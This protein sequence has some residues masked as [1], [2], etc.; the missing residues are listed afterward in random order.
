[1]EFIYGED[2][3]DPALMEAKSG[4]VVDFDH[5]LEHIRNTTQSVHFYCLPIFLL[6]RPK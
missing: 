3:L 5:L 2:G 6:Y 1:V 4:A